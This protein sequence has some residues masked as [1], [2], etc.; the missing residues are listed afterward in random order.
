MSVSS[1]ARSYRSTSLS[2]HPDEH[3]GHPRDSRIDRLSSAARRRGDEARVVAER[4]SSDRRGSPLVSRS[5]RVRANGKND[6]VSSPHTGSSRC[7][8]RRAPRYPPCGSP[9]HHARRGRSSARAPGTRRFVGSKP[10][11]F[12]SGSTTRSSTSA[13]SARLGQFP[14]RMD[15]RPR[16][17]P[18]PPATWRDRSS[19]S[20]RAR[21]GNGG[22]VPAIA[23]NEAA[24]RIPR[25]DQRRDIAPCASPRPSSASKASMRLDAGNSQ[26]DDGLFGPYSLTSTTTSASMRP[27]A[28][29]ADDVE[30]DVRR[31]RDLE[32]LQ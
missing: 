5:A 11:A 27:R 25:A 23:P 28:I 31:R 20:I 6:P 26:A 13:G 24:E 14:H 17:P 29:P 7:W 19:A 18:V 9:R 10:S 22:N 12:T 4:S 15:D 21:R 30:L 32:A 3:F 1:G 8:S 16:C 2:R